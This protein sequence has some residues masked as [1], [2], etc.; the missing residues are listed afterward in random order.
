VLEEEYKAIQK[1]I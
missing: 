1:Q